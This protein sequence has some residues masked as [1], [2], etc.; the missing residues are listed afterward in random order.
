MRFGVRLAVQGEMGE[1]GASYQRARDMTLE[2]ERLGF[3]SVWL[4]DH[5]INAHM[6]VSVPMF[7][8]WTVLSALAAETGRVRLAGHTFNNSLRNPAVLAKMAATLDVVSGGRLIYSLGSSWFRREVESYGLT[9]VEHQ[10][11]VTRL[12]EALLIADALWTRPTASFDGE[13]YT[14]RDAVLEP[15]PVQ[16]PRIPIWVPGD[17][18]AIRALAAELAD[19]W[20]IYAKEPEVIAEWHK[21]MATRRDGRPLPMAV[22]TVSLVGLS[23]DDV[24]VWA[25]KYAKEREHRFAVPPTPDDVLRE[26]LW[27]PRQQCVERIHAYAE[28]GVEELIIQPIP[29]REGMRAFAKEV[30]DD[31]V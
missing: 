2:A 16:R 14:I 10:D 20:L 4:P 5:V 1:Q 31:F 17:S 25:G 27:G 12:R 24:Q 3:H 26:N 15:K 28:A 6:D 29:P 9:W 18:E 19:V 7:E 22:S 11:R 30:M 21:E 23:D 8:C 13:H